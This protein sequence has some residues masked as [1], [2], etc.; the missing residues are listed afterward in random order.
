MYDAS[1]SI[2]IKE[3]KGGKNDDSSIN[4]DVDEKKGRFHLTVKGECP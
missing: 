3:E 2:L 1:S 4:D